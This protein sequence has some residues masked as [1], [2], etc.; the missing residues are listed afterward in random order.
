M[1]S[2]KCDGADT[3]S[4]KLRREKENVFVRTQKR[5]KADEKVYY[6]FQLLKHIFDK[7]AK[8]TWQKVYICFKCH[9]LK[10]HIY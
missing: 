6:V 1:A 5:T 9:V 4:F 7:C 2:Y 10:M 3:K 8:L